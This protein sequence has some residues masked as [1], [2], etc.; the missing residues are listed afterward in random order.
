MRRHVAGDR[1]GEAP[2]EKVKRALGI[3]DERH[4][5]VKLRRRHMAEGLQDVFADGS[6]E[7]GV[8]AQLTPAPRGGA[9]LASGDFSCASTSSRSRR[10]NSA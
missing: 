6:R 10:W 2:A 3:G 4:D 1:I 9:A 8:G 5:R 7:G